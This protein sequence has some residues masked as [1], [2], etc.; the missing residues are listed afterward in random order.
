MKR[1]LSI[2]LL[3]CVFCVS[4][5]AY[6]YVDYSADIYNS[7]YV[8]SGFDISFYS[9]DD[10]AADVNRLY[11]DDS[12]YHIELESG[13]S[14]MAVF[15]DTAVMLCYDD[16]N[17][18][19]IVYHEDL[20]SQTL[21]SFVIRNQSVLY[22]ESFGYD[23]SL[24]II[25]RMQNNLIRRYS[26]KGKLLY[27]YTLPHSVTTILQNDNANI[28]AIANSTL[29]RLQGDKATAICDGITSPA[30]FF[31]SRT[32]IDRSGDVFALSDNSCNNVVSSGS[33]QLFACNNGS[34]IIVADSS[35]LIAYSRDSGE[36]IRYF[37]TDGE[38]IGL[39]S[40]NGGIAVLTDNGTP[41]LLLLRIN[42]FTLYETP[43][44]DNPSSNS[45][46]NANDNNNAEDDGDGSITSKVYTIDNDTMQISDISP[47]STMKHF[48][49]NISYKGYTLSFY[50]NGEVTKSGYVCTA[51]TAE[52]ISDDAE[53]IYEL[54]VNGDITSDGKVSS[55]DTTLLMHYLL[56]T[57][58]FNGVYTLS[59]DMD[60]NGVLNSLD[61][62]LMKDS[63]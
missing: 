2:I 7:R 53:Y 58:E 35:K 56:G 27:T 60:R 55:K 57:A 8:S 43:S 47:S 14:E 46:S 21:D 52:F 3:L 37:D 42:D 1:M 48:R 33:D 6:T 49:D 23:G 19:L 10:T 54:S 34:Y 15:G 50:K 59:A 41:R 17:D 38:I 20:K 45:G 63:I 9:F 26:D 30:R 40:R 11:P 24:Y 44:P 31:D 36:R 13:I 18:Q 28:F 16:L 25:D 4:A 61:L 32:F 12:T 39:C 29:Y 62:V 51:M 5:A 22:E